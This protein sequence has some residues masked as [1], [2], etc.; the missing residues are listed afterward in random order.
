MYCCRDVGL[1]MVH[2]SAVDGVAYYL[3]RLYVTV[4]CS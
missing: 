3:T 4:S 1:F 2:C